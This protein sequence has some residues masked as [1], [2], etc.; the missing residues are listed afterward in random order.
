MVKRVIIAISLVLSIIL[1]S[2]DR[3]GETTG[4][5]NTEETTDSFVGDFNLIYLMEQLESFESD[6]FTCV[7]RASDNSIITRTG[8]HERD[9]NGVSYL[10]FDSGLSEGTYRFLSLRYISEDGSDYPDMNMMS[11][12]S[13]FLSRSAIA[14]PSHF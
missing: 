6:D 2:C 13:D 7:I 1:Y 8:V 3:N 9:E 5:G 12:V 14:S 4:G 10:T 11:L